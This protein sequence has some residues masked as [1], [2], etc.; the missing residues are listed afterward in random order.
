MKVNLNEAAHIVRCHPKTL[1]KNSRA[2]AVPG[3]KKKFGR[4]GF[5][6]RALCQAHSLN[7]E[8]AV[9]EVQQ[10]RAANQEA[11]K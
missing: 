4:W 1:E 3:A 6:L 10:L 9:S 7:F 11:R 5:D 2:K 8:D